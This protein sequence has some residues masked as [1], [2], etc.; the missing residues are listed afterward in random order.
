VARP[1]VLLD[2]DLPGGSHDVLRHPRDDPS[3][4]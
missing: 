2:L 4:G 1:V 3:P